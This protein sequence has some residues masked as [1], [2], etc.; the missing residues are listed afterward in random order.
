LSRAKRCI[1][2]SGISR[3]QSGKKQPTTDIRA[4]LDPVGAASR[5]GGDSTDLRFVLPDRMAVPLVHNQIYDRPPH[6]LRVVHKN[7]SLIFGGIVRARWTSPLSCLR[8]A[9]EPFR[10]DSEI[11]K[12]RLSNR[13]HQMESKAPHAEWLKKAATT[14]KTKDGKKINVYE[15]LVDKSDKAA[16]T[17]WAKHFREHY[18][19]DVKLDRLRRGTV[20]YLVARRATAL[21]LKSQGWAEQRFMPN[22]ESVNYAIFVALGASHGHANGPATGNT[23]CNGVRGGVRT[24]SG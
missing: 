10:R 13:R 15:L 24:A 4:A 12:K 22:S 9:Q 7:I 20:A 18:C 23:R 21:Q 3:G 14:L 1:L 8:S 16:L 11:K 6:A 17:A 5:A 19:L 2:N